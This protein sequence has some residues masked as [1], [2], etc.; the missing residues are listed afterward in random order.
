VGIGLLTLCLV[1]Q[2]LTLAVGSSLFSVILPPIG[3]GPCL[4]FSP[5]T[6]LQIQALKLPALAH[7]QT[8]HIPCD[9]LLR[10]TDRVSKSL[11]FG[12]ASFA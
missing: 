6:S 11:A 10:P 1:L 12:A 7:R 8:D 5:S 3:L 2:H 4:T 9:T